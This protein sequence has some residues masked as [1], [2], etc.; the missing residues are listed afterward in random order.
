MND[1]DVTP[2]EW[3]A[4]VVIYGS[5]GAMLGWGIWQYA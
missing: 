4:L 3:L 1:Q 2:L 5:I